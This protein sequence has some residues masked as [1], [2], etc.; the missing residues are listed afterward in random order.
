MTLLIALALSAPAAAVTLPAA[1]SVT[2]APTV[3]VA[4][5]QSFEEL[6]AEFEKSYDAWYERYREA[7]SRDERTR[8][9]REKPTAGFVSRF[10]ELAEANPGSEDAF[11]ALGWVVEKAERSECDDALVVLER[12]F[13]EHEGL[14]D[15][16][17][18]LR[19]PSGVADMFLRGVRKKSPHEQVQA[20]A[21]YALAQQL[22]SQVRVAEAIE[23]ASED[24]VD[25]YTDHYGGSVIYFIEKKGADKLA[26][27]AEALLVELCE[28]WGEDE[29]LEDLIAAA[30]GDLFEIQ[31]L[32]IGKVA[33]DIE[34][35]DLDGVE[36]KLSDYRGK[37]VV[38]DFWGNW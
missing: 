6:E 27:E 16:C 13:L 32:A 15:V 5:Q 9:A 3:S 2:L 25:R 28:T 7:A 37:V 4:M 31:K 35:E 17:S 30:E 33:P 22:K 8:I 24:V 21:T 38:L 11:R 10:F 14:G 18:A 26:E 34:A 23:G 1:P 29:K 36:F 12:D 19:T 20:V